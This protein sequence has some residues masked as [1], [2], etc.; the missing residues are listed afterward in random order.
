M[1]I[2]FSNK[3]INCSQSNFRD[4][5]YYHYYE[6]NGERRTAHLIIDALLFAFLFG[7]PDV[8]HLR[9]SIDPKREV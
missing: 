5:I 8:R 1:T 6:F 9:D 2:G 4:A 3:L 7:A